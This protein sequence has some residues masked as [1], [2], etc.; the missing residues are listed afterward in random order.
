MISVHMPVQEFNKS[1]MSTRNGLTLPDNRSGHWGTDDQEVFEFQFAGIKK[2]EAIVAGLGLFVT[3][4]DFDP[5][6]QEF[7]SPRID[8]FSFSIDHRLDEITARASA[9]D[10]CQSIAELTGLEVR[11]IES[12]SGVADIPVCAISDNIEQM[13]VSLHMNDQQ[14]G[15]SYTV[16]VSVSEKEVIPSVAVR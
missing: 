8:S 7:I 13:T 1:D 4:S 3:S 5:V 12:K 10:Y 14:P 15:A 2:A 6:T 11:R 16:R 9:T